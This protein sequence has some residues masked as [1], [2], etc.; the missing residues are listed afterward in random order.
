MIVR[1]SVDAGRR[2]EFKCDGGNPC[3]RRRRLLVAV[4]SLGA[5]RREIP[6]VRLFRVASWRHEGAP[7]CPPEECQIVPRGP[8]GRLDR[9]QRSVRRPVTRRNRERGR[10]KKKK[11]NDLA[12]RRRHPECVRSWGF[13][14]EGDCGRSSPRDVCVS[15]RSVRRV[16][17]RECYRRLN[18]RPRSL[19]RGRVASAVS[20]LD[21][22]SPSFGGPF[23]L[24]KR[25]Q[26]LLLL[27]LLLGLLARRLAARIPF[28]WSGGARRRRKQPRVRKHSEEDGLQRGEYLL[29]NLLAAPV[30]S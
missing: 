17:R 5:E 28:C 26:L 10:R 24:D 25:D 9:Q 18:C 4:I 30:A 21:A 29:P 12:P 20:G 19:R 27:L 14:R 23:L 3:S 8:P 22:L 6:S 15:R 7:G 1:A 13:P 11:K 2:R 16:G